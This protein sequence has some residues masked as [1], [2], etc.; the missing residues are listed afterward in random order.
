MHDPDARVERWS[1][2]WTMV[3]MPAL[4][5]RTA[6]PMVLLL[7]VVGCTRGASSATP[8]STPVDLGGGTLRVAVDDWGRV[9]WVGPHRAWDAE[10]DPS[11]EYGTA[12][13]ASSWELFRCCLLRTLL[14]YNGL[15][16]DKNGAEP[17]PDLARTMP[18]VSSDGLTWTFQLK[19]GLAYAPPLQT[20]AITSP[21]IIRAIERTLSPATKLQQRYHYPYL[22]SS[23]LASYFTELIQGARAFLDRT[24]STIS[25][26]S[27]PDPYTL[28]VQLTRPSGDL[29][30]RMSLP[31][32]AP[33]PP[34]PADPGAQLGVATG[35]AAGY[36]A[37]LV[38]SGPYMIEG[39]G[40]IDFVQPP[41]E[42]QPASGYTPAEVTFA[43]KLTKP[44]TLVLVRNPSWKDDNL[45]S[46]YPDRIVVTLTD[47]R[48][49]AQIPR[50]V[51]N[52]SID[53]SMADTP[54]VQAARYLEDPLLR[55]R[56][57]TFPSDWIYFLFLNT[58][59]PPFDDLSVRRA[60]AFVVNR[61]RLAG[62][63]QGVAG[64]KPDVA[65]HIVP[66]GTES[67]L[68]QAYA[69]FGD[70]HGD[71]VAAQNEMRHSPYD[72]NGDGKCDASVC[73]AILA[74]GQG[75]DHRPEMTAEVRSALGRIGITL[76][77]RFFPTRA[78]YYDG[79]CVWNPSKRVGIEINNGWGFDYPD[80]SNM[81][82]NMFSE[83]YYDPLTGT[84]YDVAKLGA[85]RAQLRGWGYSVTHTP[86]V[87]SRIE[88]CLLVIGGEETACWAELDQFMTEQ[89]VP[90]VPFS[91]GTG[92]VAV[93]DRI[94]RMSI[95]Q[96]TGQ[97]ALDRAVIRPIGSP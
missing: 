17:Q 91:F 51:D 63:L 37:F 42:Q 71:V 28:V 85:T 94:Q 34:S 23:G 4:V 78:S 32:T 68:N 41:S 79:C 46:A 31:V 16:A 82:L 12:T 43:G 50:A 19:R 29:A 70:P 72:A 21:D 3:S 66:D 1:E 38:A 27:A 30:Y 22:G 75:W 65:T 69:P 93:S 10:L 11:Y 96:L 76:R 9:G 61:V 77:V 24:A 55:D 81:F 86:S 49:A 97:P 58:A 2:R 33:I 59:V 44:G 84:S 47:G 56:L 64:L 45:R 53:F 26:L 8:P 7:L 95:D 90:V 40:K 18:D 57:V 6:A 88:R 5:T 52:G 36:G 35:H 14:S 48:F 92:F 73:H 74:Y 89:V 15:S 87:D 60:V 54:T 62:L 83:R 67:S 39:A 80:P 13:A 20:I 25:G